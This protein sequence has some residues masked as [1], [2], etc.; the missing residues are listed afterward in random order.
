MDDCICTYCAHAELLDPSEMP[1]ADDEQRGYFRR[2]KK[3]KKGGI[4]EWDYVCGE[5]E[6]VRPS[7]SY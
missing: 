6:Q 3:G 4:V 5:C 7:V 1:E 2:C